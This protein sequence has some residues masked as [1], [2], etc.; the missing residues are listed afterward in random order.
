[1]W[2]IDEV[3]A[4]LDSYFKIIEEEAKELRMYSIFVSTCGI[5]AKHLFFAQEKGLIHHAQSK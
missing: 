2:S 3:D 1:M 4:K 5:L